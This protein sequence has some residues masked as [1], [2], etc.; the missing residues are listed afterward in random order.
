MKRIQTLLLIL[1]LGLVVPLAASAGDDRAASRQSDAKA[2]DAAAP[3]STGEV[4]KVD[5]DAV[6]SLS[7]TARWNTS[8]CPG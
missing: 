4:K 1:T 8:T 3:M 7:S 2:T 5:K 6:R